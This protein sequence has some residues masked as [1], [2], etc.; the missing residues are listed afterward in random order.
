M[1][2]IWVVSNALLLQTVLQNILAQAFRY[3]AAHVSV[4]QLLSGSAHTVEQPFFFADS[5]SNQKHFF[6]SINSLHH[7]VPNEIGIQSIFKTYLQ[8]V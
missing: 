7:Y 4:A 1:T 2:S 6:H 3:T 5:A 8:Q